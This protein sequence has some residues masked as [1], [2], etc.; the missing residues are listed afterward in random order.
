MT[1]SVSAGR[2][3]GRVA[4]G[5]EAL[6]RRDDD[7]AT[8]ADLHALEPFEQAGERA[9]ASSAPG[10]ARASQVLS[11]RDAVVAAEQHEVE[12]GGLIGLDRRAVAL[13]EVDRG[14][15]GRALRGRDAG[16]GRGVG[17]DRTPG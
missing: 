5:A 3:I 2:P 17:R 10:S 9:L 1:T 13:D 11:S 4:L 7:G 12:H 16:F 8:A 6:V 14:D 15:L